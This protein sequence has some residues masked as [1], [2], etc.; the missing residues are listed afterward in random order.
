MLIQSLYCSVMI[1]RMQNVAIKL[2]CVY[3]VNEMFN[4]LH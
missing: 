4:F 1:H 2:S 3:R